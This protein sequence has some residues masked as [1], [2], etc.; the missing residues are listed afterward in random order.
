MN[1]RIAFSVL[2]AVFL[3]SLALP[4]SV[5]MAA[6]SESKIKVTVD[7]AT[8]A[9]VYISYE[10]TD[11]PDFVEE[12]G[13]GLLVDGTNHQT[14][15][16]ISVPQNQCYTVWVERAGTLF[17]IKGPE[18]LP[19]QGVWTGTGTM[20]ASGCVET[21]SMYGIHFTSKVFETNEPPVANANGPYEACAGVEITFDGS[22]SYDPDPDDTLEYRW[23]FED[24][25]TYDTDWSS[26]PYAT[27]TW[28]QGHTGTVR[29]QVR[30]LFA[31]TPLG[32]TDTDT[33][34]VTV[35]ALPTASAS[36]NSPVCEGSDINLTGGP[37]GMT[38]YS[39]SGPGSYSS[40]AQSP[41]ISSAS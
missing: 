11:P 36:S 2:S 5:P 1:K 8:G 20:Y 31:G 41:T 32:T 9:W 13:T 22:A 12:V 35:Y 26:S 14:P 23:D 18:H 40:S 6:A 16:Q 10:G 17:M 34:T 29:L 15:V 7:G 24:D 4:A 27:H 21:H 37:D 25:G 38:T 19:S 30:D 39:W 28:N 33:A 3:V